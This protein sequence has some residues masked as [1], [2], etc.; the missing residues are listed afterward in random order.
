VDRHAD[1]LRASAANPG[2]D[3]RL[4]ANEAPRNHLSFLGQFLVDLLEN[5]SKGKAT[6]LKAT[7]SEYRSGLAAFS[8]VRQYRP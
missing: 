1:K 5:I 7:V 2:N 4:G 8:S 6:E 3:L